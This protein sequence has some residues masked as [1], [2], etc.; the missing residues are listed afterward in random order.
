MTTRNEL[1]LMIA[2]YVANRGAITVCPPCKK[3]Y[4]WAT[5]R[6]WKDAI[7]R[8]HVALEIA[9]LVTKEEE[10]MILKDNLMTGEEHSQ[11]FAYYMTDDED[12]SDVSEIDK[13]S[14]GA[15]VWS[16]MDM[17][18]V[19]AMTADAQRGLNHNDPEWCD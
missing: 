8:H 4:P 15:D 9:G 10:D 19:G 14:F 11:V 18:L 3:A 6:D 2:G 16:M 13:A 17:H 1:N 5:E 7:Q 12:V